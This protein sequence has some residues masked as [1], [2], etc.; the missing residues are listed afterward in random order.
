[1]SN[2]TIKKKKKGN[3][4]PCIIFLPFL[5]S[6]MVVGSHVSGALQLEKRPSPAERS[7]QHRKDPFLYLNFKAGLYWLAN[8]SWLNGAHREL[9][10]L[11][12][13]PS[14]YL[15]ER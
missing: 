12:A 13:K 6:D 9:H 2:W 7:H 3:Q 11:P 10:L 1:M 4:F 14:I 8:Y 15:A 5:R